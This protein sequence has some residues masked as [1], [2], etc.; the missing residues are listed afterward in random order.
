[1]AKEQCPGEC[2]YGLK[3]KRGSR[4]GSQE[5]VKGKGAGGR[6]GRAPPTTNIYEHQ[7]TA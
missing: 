6:A 3:G 4:K 2:S 5:S 1:M 7:D